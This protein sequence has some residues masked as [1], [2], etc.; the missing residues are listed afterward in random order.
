MVRK[1]GVW[2][3]SIQMPWVTVPT[4]SIINGFTTQAGNPLAY[5]VVDLVGGRY[6][7]LRGTLVVPNPRPVVSTLFWT[8][9][10]TAFMHDYW[11]NT[12]ASAGWN[13]PGRRSLIRTQGAGYI[14]HSASS[15]G[16]GE[17][18]DMAAVGAIRLANA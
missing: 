6:M 12:Q 14:W 7:F 5:A 11:M 1:N 2:V 10:I 9:P 8:G 4:A 18:I 3:P 16:A 15:D 17:V 13:V